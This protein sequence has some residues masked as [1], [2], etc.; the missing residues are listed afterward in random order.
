MGGLPALPR[1][2]ALIV[3]RLGSVAV[4]GT[5]SLDHGVVG[6]S[7]IGPMDAV[8]I[9][10]RPVVPYRGVPT[11]AVPTP[12]ARGHPRLGEDVD[13]VGVSSSS[14]LHSCLP[15]PRVSR[16]QRLVALF[17]V[18]DGSRSSSREPFKFNPLLLKL[19]SLDRIIIA[20]S[21]M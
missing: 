6:Q 3:D 11:A 10:W 18:N 9:V 20:Y 21:F 5:S 1:S 2:R 19:L 15:V 17:G 16:L 7:R 12:Q 13:R 14:E 8:A 4:R